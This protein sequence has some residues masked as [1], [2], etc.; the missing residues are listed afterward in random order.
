[1]N[2]TMTD[3]VAVV[4]SDISL[5]RAT[6]RGLGLEPTDAK[7]SVTYLGVDD[8]AGAKRAAARARVKQRSRLWGMKLRL[9]KIGRF[10]S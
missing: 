7:A 6:V 2:A 9:K 4:A 10:K 8:S 3:N 1:M 5:A